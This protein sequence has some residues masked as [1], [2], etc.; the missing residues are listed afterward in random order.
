MHMHLFLRWYMCES[1][2]SLP[3][4]YVRRICLLQPDS[5][6]YLE[7]KKGENKHEEISFSP[8]FGDWPRRGSRFLQLGKATR[9]ANPK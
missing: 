5:V 2:H 1:D 3:R 6:D 4:W 9:T 8:V 7:K